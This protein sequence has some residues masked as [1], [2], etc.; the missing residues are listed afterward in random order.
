MLPPVSPRAPVCGR[1]SALAFPGTKVGRRHGMRVVRLVLS[2]AGV[3]LLAYLIVRIGTEP[4]VT[5]LSRLVWWQ[6]ALVCLPYAVIMAVDALAWRYAFTSDRTPLP[7]LYGARMAGDAVN[8]VTPAASIGGEG[9]KAWLL[10]PYVSYEESVPSLVIA[11]TTSTIG[12]G[13]FL[14]LGVAVAWL[15]LDLDSQLM[16]SMLWLLLAE[17]VLL[18]GFVLAQLTGAIGG[19]GRMLGR[20]GLPAGAIHAERLEASLRHFYRDRRP[21]LLMSTALHFVGWALGGLEVFL[22]LHALGVPLSLTAALV[23]EAFGAAVRFAAFLIPASIGV[24]EAANAG[25]FDALGVGAGA[26]LAFSFLRRARQAVWVGL[27]L[28]VLVGMRARTERLAAP[29]RQPAP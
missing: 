24:S 28:L 17:S 12:Q 18:G 27:G 26:G 25:I 2:I 13:L 10:H 11:K 7:A 5:T 20:L 16:R 1:V 15:I 23:V 29:A 3:A 4:I 8:L 6:F 22:M 9:V 21:R 14:L 19:V